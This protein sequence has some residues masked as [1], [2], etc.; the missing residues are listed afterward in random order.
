MKRARWIFLGAFALFLLLRL[1]FPTPTITFHDVKEAS[2]SIQAV[3]FRCTSDRVDGIVAS[4]FMVTEEDA[5]WK[6]ANNLC[7]SGPMGPEWKGKVWVS[8][9][10]AHG[11]YGTIPEN[12]PTRSWGGVVAFG[13][14]K[15][16]DQLENTL[17]RAAGGMM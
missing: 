1:F 6:D 12:A 17:Q 15:L 7:K 4:G 14:A 9:V 11:T 16:L 10:P 13:D 3:G 8:L 2:N 5:T